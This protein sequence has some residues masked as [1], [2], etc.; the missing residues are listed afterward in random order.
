MLIVFRKGPYESEAL[1]EKE[2]LEPSSKNDKHYYLEV[3]EDNNELKSKSCE[4]DKILC[5]RS[6][7]SGRLSELVK[8]AKGKQFSGTQVFDTF[9]SRIEQIF[10]TQMVLLYDDAQF[11]IENPK[12]G[13]EV[14][15]FPLRE[16]K[17]L[18]ND[19]VQGLS[20]YEEKGFSTS[21]CRD[22]STVWPDIAITQNPQEYREAIKVIR[23]TTLDDLHRMLNAYPRTKGILHKLRRDYVSTLSKP[24]IHDLVKSISQ[25]MRHPVRK[26][27]ALKDFDQFYKQAIEP[28]TPKILPKDKAFFRFESTEAFFKAIHTLNEVCIFQKMLG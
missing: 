23:E 4:L 26:F 9:Y 12:T 18:A 28:W 2:F 21:E 27:K 20:W 16:L 24:T 17:A 14:S 10:K 8:I 15:C 7:P 13:K 5:V 19:D 22:F 6:S 3:F 25:Q 11:P 1:G